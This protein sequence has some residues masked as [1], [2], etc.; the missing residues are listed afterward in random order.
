M[1]LAEATERSAAG[2]GTFEW[3]EEVQKQEGWFAWL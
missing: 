2:L 1:S 3:T